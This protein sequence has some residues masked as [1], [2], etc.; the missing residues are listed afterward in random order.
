MSDNKTSDDATFDDDDDTS[1]IPA[2]DAADERKGPTTDDKT[3]DET[4]KEPSTTAS[5]R[6]KSSLAG[7]VAALALLLS[8]AALGL[9][10]YD[11]YRDRT[12]ADLNEQSGSEVQALRSTLRES[13]ANAATLN[14]RVS[15]AAEA[16]SE[17]RAEVA[18]LERE[19]ESRLSSLDALPG[20]LAAVE[21]SMSAVQGISTSVRDAWLIA[22][23]EYYLQIANAQLQL[24]NNP[25]LA[26]IALS[27]ADER[28]LQL[29]DP[30]LT[31]VRR[32]LSDERRA[33]EAMEKPDT[34]GISLALSSLAS[35]VDSLPLEDRILVRNADGTE[36]DPTL[37]G[38]DRAVASLKN[39]MTSVVSV[40]RSDE[41]VKPL[42]APEAQFFLRAN[43]SLQLQSARLALLR[44]DEEV[45]RQ[46]LTDAES[47]LEEYYDTDSAGVQSAIDTLAGFRGSVLSVSM[48][49]ISESLRRLRQFRTLAA[50]TAE[51][52]AEAEQ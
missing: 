29:S 10:A 40:R 15:D 9:A 50:A 36:V 19:L 23:A 24:A 11:I 18:T 21:A 14:A 43:L 2:N 5:A 37:T 12:L 20:R 47:W 41:A 3:A 26:G 45:F 38:M 39:A 6:R 49:D 28:L 17:L 25:S 22:E 35:T 34:T 48:P 30:R 51:Q 33:L 7:G 32:A 42:I 27:H 13:E 1:L 44:G 8:L 46:S 52:E 16:N 4:P 31:R